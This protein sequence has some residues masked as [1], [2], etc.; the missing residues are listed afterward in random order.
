MIAHNGLPCS[1]LKEAIVGVE[2]LMGEKKKPLPRREG[3]GRDEGNDMEG[4]ES[5]IGRLE[6]QM[7]TT[8]HSVEHHTQHHTTYLDTPP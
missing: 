5:G 6:S 2:H 7:G 8:E 1:I 4:E 3:G